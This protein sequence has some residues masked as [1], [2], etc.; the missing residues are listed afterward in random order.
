VGRNHLFDAMRGIA[1]ILVVAYHFE[2]FSLKLVPSGFVAV[3]FFFVL[4]GF[5]IAQAYEARLA[6][7]LGLARFAEIRLVRLYPLVF[8]GVMLGL[9]RALVSTALHQRLAYTPHQIAIGFPFNLLILPAPTGLSDTFP[10]NGP[11][12]SL[13]FEMVANVLFAITAFRWPRAALATLIVIGGVGIVV[14]A[15]SVG[16]ADIGWEWRSIAG[17]FARVAYG[18]TWGHLLFRLSDRS[19]ERASSWWSL[20]IIAVLAATLVAPVSGTMGFAWQLTAMLLIAPVLVAV[21]SRIDLPVQ[22]HKLAAI[23]GDLSYPL[24]ALHLPLMFMIG[25]VLRKLHVPLIAFPFV[26][27]PVLLAA[28]FIAARFF[29]DPV[30]ARLAQWLKVRQSAR[31]QVV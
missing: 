18:F 5:V 24:Y 26:L 15:R 23:L 22:L 19:R 8:L 29:D 9:V 12:W 27:L 10:L 2:N 17:G 20:V 14:V 11:V 21:A 25:F 28:A 3:D 1:A 13:F 4:S 30:R 16:I 6:G 7:G 31:A